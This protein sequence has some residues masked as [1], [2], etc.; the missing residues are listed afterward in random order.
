MSIAYL[1][2]ETARQLK[3]ARSLIFSLAVP[4]VMLF[5]FGGAFG[6]GGA[7][8]KTTGLPWIMVTTLQMA[9]YG[10]MIAGLS[11]SFSIVTERQ[12]GW[13]RQLR[14]TP[15]S[16]TGYLLSKMVSAIVLAAVAIVVIM[17]LSASV[18]HPDLPLA[19][20]LAAGF[21]ILAGVI[22]FA[23]IAI[24]IGQFA[25]P[26]WAQP[27]FMAVFMGLS[28]LGG[29]WIPLQIFP[30]WVANIGRAVPSYWLNRL[31]IMGAKLDGDFVTP[32]LVLLGWTIV[33]GAFIIWR[34]R[35]DAARD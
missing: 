1:G 28:L 17:A 6:A 24:I 30:A 29:L 2:L 18:F 12:L 31:G 10:A 9:A 4:V 20:W 26:D 19:G 27:M 13:N 32:A 7:V 11:Q 14:I 8:D 35:R 21:G 15:L 33:L 25:K 16:G 34:Y 5:A 3:N 22:P 23:L